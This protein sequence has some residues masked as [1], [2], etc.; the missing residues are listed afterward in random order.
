MC[1]SFRK[2]VNT[3]EKKRVYRRTDTC[4]ACNR[5]AAIWSRN[6]KYRWGNVINKTQNRLVHN[7]KD[8]Q[9]NSKKSVIIISRKRRKAPSTCSLSEI[10]YI[11]LNIFV[12]IDRF[13]LVLYY[14]LL[15]TT[16]HHINIYL[17]LRTSDYITYVHF[18]IKITKE[19][20]QQKNIRKN[21]NN[22]VQT[23]FWWCFY[24]PLHYISLLG[25]AVHKEYNKSVNI[26]KRA[27]R[28]K[29]H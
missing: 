4:V 1:A 5:K 13:V 27:L 23:S 14:L 29:Q 2:S 6:W 11:C 15:N 19:Q 16:I 12:C 9:K 25:S 7:N 20:Q 3:S 26:F 24:V 17:T 21:K 10:L 18:L 22:A 28:I 8:K